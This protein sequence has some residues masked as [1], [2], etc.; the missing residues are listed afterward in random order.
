MNSLS[1]NY[2]GIGNPRTVRAL[3]DL[4]QQWNPEIFFLIKTKVGV[5]RMIKVKERNGFPNGL[6]VPNEG[7][8]GGIALLWI[9]EM[10]VEI[11]NFLRFHIDAV[12]TDHSLDL[13]WRLTGF[14]GNPDT[15]LRRES[16]NLLR[17]LNSQYQMPWM[18][19]GDYNEILSAI[20]KNGGPKRSQK[21]MEGFRNVINEYGFQDMGKIIQEVW[22]NHSGLQ[23]SNGLVEGIKD[24][25]SRLGG[26][27]RFDLGHIPRNIQEKRKSLQAMIQADLDGSNG[28]EIDRLSKEIN[29]LLDVE[30]KKWHQRSRV[31]WYQ[32]GDRNTQFFHHKPSQHKKKNGINGL[33]DKEGK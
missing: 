14:Y 17:M 21:Q 9:R 12:V 28:E 15:N 5:R 6:V 1:W 30:E 25:A 10:E 18:C 27:N 29:E 11:K 4:V 26:W 13:K 2:R 24:C 32:K 16:W 20:E 19:I 23:S 22:K 8:S 33:W 3:R 31:Q 7:K